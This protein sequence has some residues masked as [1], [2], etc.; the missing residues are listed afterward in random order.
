MDNLYRGQY[1]RQ[2]GGNIWTSGFKGLKPL[3]L[4]LIE[5]MKPISKRGAK[6]L[7]KEVI[8]SAK[9][10]T[11][12]VLNSPEKDIPKRIKS[13]IQTEKTRLKRKIAD[14][15][16]KG[17]GAKRRKVNK[18]VVKVTKKIPNKVVKK[19]GAKPQKK[20]VNKRKPPIKRRVKKCVKK[21]DIFS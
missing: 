18:R 16:Q 10:V 14:H 2:I 4:K 9:N 20:V 12:H 5:R 13:A 7:R 17:S 1:R 8:Q 19:K 21:S 15:L 11:K 6:T 3:I